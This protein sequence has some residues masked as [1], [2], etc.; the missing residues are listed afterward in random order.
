MS[1]RYAVIDDATQ[2]VVNVVLWDGEND[3]TPPEGCTAVQSDVAD[4]GDTYE[5][6]EFIPPPPSPDEPPP[7]AA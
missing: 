4:I 7:E 6:G 1:D 3:W 5:D 2:V